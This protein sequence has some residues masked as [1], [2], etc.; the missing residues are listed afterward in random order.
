MTDEK[1]YLFTD[2]HS[3][4]AR[5]RKYFSHLLNIHG[6]NDVRHTE[7]H[8]AVTEPSATEVELAIE[9]LKFKNHWILME[10]QQ[11]KLL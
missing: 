8:A 9:K 1:G 5:W 4:L 10:S 3:I 6:I 7:I 11:K 2:S